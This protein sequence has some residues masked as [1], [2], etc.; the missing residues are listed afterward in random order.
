MTDILHDD[1]RLKDP[2]WLAQH[3]VRD[4]PGGAF[5]HIR[6]PGVTWIKD[7]AGQVT[8]GRIGRPSVQM[9]PLE[10]LGET[11]RQAVLA[12]IAP[13]IAEKVKP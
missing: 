9:I 13:Q 3:A 4:C 11:M 5:P 8:D 6:V 7:Y 2:K 12:Q 1:P 10:W